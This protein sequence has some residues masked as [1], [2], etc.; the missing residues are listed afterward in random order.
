MMQQLPLSIVQILLIVAAVLSFIE[1][2]LTAAAADGFGPFSHHTV[3][4][5][6]F[7]SVW[8][9]L[10]IA[11]LGLTPIFFAQLFHQFASLALLGV[12][13][14]FWFAGS[15]A[16]ASLVGPARCGGFN[17]CRVAQAGAAFGFFV[18]LAFTAL[19]VLD[20]IDF[21]R[22]RNSATSPA[23]AHPQMGSAAPASA[24][25]PPAPANTYPG[26]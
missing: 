26:A 13:T 14:I 7:N 17:L 12:T 21:V 1:L 20:I 9:L 15:I 24:E 23:V 3:N 25:A 6:V 10:V 18:W 5:M 16:Y 4:F 2:A 19:L 22:S 8:S 11:Y